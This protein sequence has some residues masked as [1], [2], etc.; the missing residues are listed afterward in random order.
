M[1]MY[2][3]SSKEDPVLIVETRCYSLSDLLTVSR[4]HS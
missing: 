3:I 1:C 4:E 2:G